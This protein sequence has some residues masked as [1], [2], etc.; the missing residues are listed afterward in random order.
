[1][2]LNNVAVSPPCPDG[3]L[4]LVLFLSIF[5]ALAGNSVLM[6]A[7]YAPVIGADELKV[8]SN[9]WASHRRLPI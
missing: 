5:S 9:N 7:K 8:N 1:M 2:L 3:T 4:N 6:S